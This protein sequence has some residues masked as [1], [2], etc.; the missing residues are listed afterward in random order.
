MQFIR[1][2]QPQAGSSTP[3]CFHLDLRAASYAVLL[4]MTSQYKADVPKHTLETLFSA[5][6]PSNGILNSEMVKI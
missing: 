2:E 5:G 3:K 1:S 6:H 4:S